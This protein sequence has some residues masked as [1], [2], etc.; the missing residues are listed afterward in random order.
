[1]SQIPCTVDDF[2]KDN[3]PTID[4]MLEHWETSREW[5]RLRG[6]QLYDLQPELETSVCRVWHTPLTSTAAALPYARC[7]WYEGIASTT[8]LT[9][10]CAEFSA[11]TPTHS[12]HW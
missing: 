6:I 2:G 9:K 3:I 8:F 10:V 12:V 7:V 5:L 4:D 1:M 11:N